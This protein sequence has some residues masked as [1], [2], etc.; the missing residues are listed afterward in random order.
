MTNEGRGE[1]PAFYYYVDYRELPSL[2]HGTPYF[3][4]QYRQE[5]P[6]EPGRNYLILDAEGRGHYVGCNLSVLQ[7]AMGWWGEGDDMIYVDGETE[8]SLHG[9]GSEDY[10]SDAWGMRERPGPFYGCPLQEE[11]FQAGSKATVYRFHIPDPI[12]FTK[13][14]RVTIEHGHANDRADFDSST[15]YWYQAEPHKAFPALPAGRGPPALRP[16][17]ARQFRPA[18]LEAEGAGRR[19]A[20]FSRTP[21]GGSGSRRPS[22]LL[23]A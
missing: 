3:H 12:P 22:W 19:A 18:G 23:A 7:R 16:R 2:P 8:P 1:V 20:R 5:F 11:D 15:A 17:A 21:S 9:T 4:A 10:F 6:P 13:S 14:I